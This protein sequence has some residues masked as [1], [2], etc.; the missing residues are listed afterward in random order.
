MESGVAGRAFQR[1]RPRAL[2]GSRSEVNAPLDAPAEG[3][4]GAHSWVVA[5]DRLIPRACFQ[6]R[7]DL[8]SMKSGFPCRENQKKIGETISKSVSAHADVGIYAEKLNGTAR[9]DG[10]RTG[11]SGNGTQRALLDGQQI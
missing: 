2:V 10:N 5:L 3:P 1:G 6:E 7:F 4:H 11:K 8:Y 9:Y